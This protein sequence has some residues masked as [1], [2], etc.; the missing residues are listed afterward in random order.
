METLDLL[1]NNLA[2]A[3]TSGYK[4]DREY[5]SLY[6]GAAL[7]GGLG[8]VADLPAVQGQWTDFKQ[9]LIEETG[10]SSDLALKGPGL[11]AVNGPNG[12]L[13]TRNGSF[14]LNQDGVL[15][16][17]EG[18]SVRLRGGEE[19]QVSSRAPLDI[20]SDG[21]IRQ[22]GRTLG[23]LEIAEFSDQQ[24][25][26]KQGASYFRSLDSEATPEEATDTEVVQGH[27]EASNVGAAEAAVR[28]VQVMRQFEMLQRTI[29]MASEMD[30][31]AIRDVAS[32]GS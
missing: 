25:L 16:T 5:Y 11:F 18:Y 15:V 4:T 3:N 8:Q 1:A 13:Y 29:S 2:N 19:L 21:E 6:H 14:Q 10:N 20:S 32:V 31:K 30:R 7:G 28:L 22:S 23:R 17:A 12:T 24:L 26:V 27:L 9:G